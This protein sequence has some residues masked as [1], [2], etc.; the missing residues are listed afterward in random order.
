MGT[1]YLERQTFRGKKLNLK[2][3]RGLSVRGRSARDV[4]PTGRSLRLTD[5]RTIVRVRFKRQKYVQLQSIFRCGPRKSHLRVIF[6]DVLPISG[7]VLTLWVKLLGRDE[8]RVGRMLNSWD[9][10]GEDGW[11]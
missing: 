3:L 2:I 10:M 7:W 8:E 1:G 4:V 11:N 6:K 5:S 9:S